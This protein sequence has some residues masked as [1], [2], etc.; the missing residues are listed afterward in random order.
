MTKRKFTPPSEA[1]E[2]HEWETE[3]GFPVIHLEGYHWARKYDDGTWMV[4]SVQP[5]GRISGSPQS[6]VIVDKPKHGERTVWAN[7]YPR[8]KNASSHPDKETADMSAGKTRLAC[9]KITI[10]YTE[11]QFDE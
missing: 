9:V 2:G 8:P 7:I 6:P 5:S 4:Y 1:K 11:G 10:P 3:D